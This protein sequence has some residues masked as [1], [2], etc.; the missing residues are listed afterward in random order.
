MKE[1]LFLFLVYTVSSAFLVLNF[2]GVYWDG[3][4]AYNQTL[5]SQKAFFNEFNNDIF[6]QFYLFMHEI[7][8]GL[9][10]YRVF[11]FLAYFLTS[12]A[13]FSIL[14]TIKELSQT[15]VFYIVVFY[16]LMP[17]ISSRVSVSIIPF[18]FPVLIFFISFL[19]LAKYLKNDFHLLRPIILIGFFASFYTNSILVFYATVMLYIFY[20]KFDFSFSIQNVKKFFLRYLDFI[21]LPIVFFLIKVIYFK[22]TGLYATYNTVGE[23][24]IFKVI[25]QLVKSLDSALFDVLHQAFYITFPFWLALVVIIFLILKK[26]KESSEIYILNDHSKK[27]LLFGFLLFLLAVFPY[28]A[29]SK[30]PRVDGFESRF[31]LLTPLGLAFIFYFGINIIVKYFNFDKKI[32][33]ILLVILVFSF[34]TKNISDYY[35]FQ[36]DN[37]YMTSIMMNFKQ[38]KAIEANTTFILNNNLR[39]KLVYKRNPPFYEWTGILKKAFGNDKRLM[40]SYGQYKKLDGIRKIQEYEHYNFFNWIEKKPVLVTISKNYKQRVTDRVLLKLYLLK[41]HDYQKYLN[42]VKKL[43]IV[44]TEDFK[45]MT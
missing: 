40:V 29:V 39:E 10:V 43:T 28:V 14:N 23:D 7:G 12:L 26:V 44:M 19:L 22:P 33:V 34:V 6:Y 31:Q 27:F 41:F 2:D 37:L 18:F 38:S 8:N 1:I 36:I 20:I 13:I 17:I 11:V 30:L 24:S 21:V 35:K 42:E 4:I 5:S 3:W 32:K 15:D 9:L 25:F 45:E 16:L